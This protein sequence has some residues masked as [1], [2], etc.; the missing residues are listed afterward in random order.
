MR[1]R[2]SST[3]SRAPRYVL[4]S[5]NLVHCATSDTS[6]AARPGYEGLQICLTIKMALSSNHHIHWIRKADTFLTIVKRYKNI[7][8][9]SDQH[10]FAHALV[11]R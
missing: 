10:A 1:G 7:N 11:L 5:L 4:D 9:Q 2:V 6:S 3:F 8:M